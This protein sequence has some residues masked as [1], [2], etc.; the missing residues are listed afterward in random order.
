LIKLDDKLFLM[1]K[2]LFI[3]IWIPVFYTVQAQEIGMRLGDMS[4]N[5]VAIDGLI[6]MEAARVHADVSFGNGVGIVVVYDFIYR[7]IVEL[8]DFYYYLGAG[9]TTLLVSDYE[10][11]AVGEAGIEY[12]FPKSPLTISLDYRPAIIVLEKS[13][14][15]WN[16]FGLNLRY[17]IGD[18]SF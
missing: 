13:D 17:V 7:P 2:L 3:L 15:H 14:F 5:N 12:R 4:G 11:G 1:K 16:G 9:I 6:E 8:P 18:V 10:L